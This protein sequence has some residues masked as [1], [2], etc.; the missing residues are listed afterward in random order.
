[1]CKA[2]V[3]LELADACLFKVA[4]DLSLI[5]GVHGTDEVPAGVS[6]RH[7]L[8]KLD[9]NKAKSVNLILRL[10]LNLASS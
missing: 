5:V 3:V 9:H 10:K 2:A 7:R 8:N 4:A 1:M 6:L